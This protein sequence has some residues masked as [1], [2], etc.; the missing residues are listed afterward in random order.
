MEN[1]IGRHGIQGA[2]DDDVGV[3][4]QEWPSRSEASTIDV[5]DGP[6][7]PSLDDRL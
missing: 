2:D 6:V 3:V 4:L 1:S 7:G 5:V